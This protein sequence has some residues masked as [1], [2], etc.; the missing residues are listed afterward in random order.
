MDKRQQRINNFFAACVQ[1]WGEG[2]FDYSNTKFN[3]ESD[4]IEIKCITHNKPFTQKAQHHKN[5]RFGC[6]SCKAEDAARRSLT[7][8]K[9]TLESI[10]PELIHE[11][12]YEEYHRVHGKDILSSLDKITKGSHV[13]LPWKCNKCNHQWTARVKDRVGT[14]RSKGTNCPACESRAV[15]DNNNLAIKFP[16]IAADWSAKN[17]ASPENFLPNSHVKVWWKC[18][19]DPLHEYYMEISKRT[20]RNSGCPFCRHRRASPEFLLQ[21]THPEI[22]KQFHPT[23]NTKLISEITYG[24][25][26]HAWWICEHGKEFRARVCDRSSGN[27]RCECVPKSGYSQK[28]IDWLNAIMRSENIQIQHAANGKEY[29]I[30]GT[31]FR[32]DGYCAATNTIYEFHGDYWHGNPKKYKLDEVNQVIGKTFGEL[33][34]KT[35]DRESAIIDMGYN[36]VVKWEGDL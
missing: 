16:L 28:A 11:I 32:A 19:I 20:T 3:A 7:R 2:K 25:G 13:E 15:S 23:K 10:R 31:N 22:A 27:V 18:N 30:P 17:V 9:D 33:Y 6:E 26:Y 4:Q 8:G 34:Q 29:K 14:E 12:D 36:L 1:Q 35:I 5:G 24:M 21:N